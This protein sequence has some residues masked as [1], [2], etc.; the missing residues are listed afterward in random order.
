MSHP[1][2]TQLTIQSTKKD[3]GSTSIT[4]WQHQDNKRKLIWLKAQIW[5]TLPFIPTHNSHQRQREKRRAR[6]NMFWEWG[7]SSAYKWIVKD[8]LKSRPKIL[9]SS[10]VHIHCFLPLVLACFIFEISG[11]GVYP[12]P[13]GTKVART[14]VGARVSRRAHAEPEL[15]RVLAGLHHSDKKRSISVLKRPESASGEPMNHFPGTTQPIGRKL[16]VHTI[17]HS[18]RIRAG[19]VLG[20]EHAGRR[21]GGVWTPPV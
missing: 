3:Q 11:G 9:Y 18:T 10:S 8:A 13:V 19:A 21:A 17:L 12:P 15:G 7:K 1:R 16:K 14:P 5:N 20:A 2:T 4:N 6:V